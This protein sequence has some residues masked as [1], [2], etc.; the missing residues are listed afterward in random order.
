M[1]PLGFSIRLLDDFSTLKLGTNE[2]YDALFVC[3][4][5]PSQGKNQ[6]CDIPVGFLERD[7]ERIKKKV[8][9]LAIKTNKKST[10]TIQINK[11]VNY[12]I[13]GDL[14]FYTYLIPHLKRLPMGLA[15]KPPKKIVF[16]CISH[17]VQ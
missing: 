13:A 10:F 11:K 6:F 17:H 7:T 3:L 1:T 5:V 16:P 14:L 2:S 9:I 15:N 4:S 8:L 12:I